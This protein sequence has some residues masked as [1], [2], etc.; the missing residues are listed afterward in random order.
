MAARTR[1]RALAAALLLCC[2][3]AGAAGC[4]QANPVPAYEPVLA[5]EANAA[6]GGKG[7]AGKIRVGPKQGGG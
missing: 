4:R 5:L 1:S 6:I 2:I 3:G 7:A